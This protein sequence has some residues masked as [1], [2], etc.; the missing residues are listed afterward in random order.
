MRLSHTDL[1]NKK[2]HMGFSIKS[3]ESSQVMPVE[4]KDAITLMIGFGTFVIVFLT[5]IL[6]IIELLNQNKKK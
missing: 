3:H 6:R 4:V 1:H 5:L 2:G